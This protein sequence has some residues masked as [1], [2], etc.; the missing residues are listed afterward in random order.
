[1]SAVS[2]TEAKAHLNIAANL[3]DEELQSFLDRAEAAIGQRVGPVGS[4]SIEDERVRGYCAVLRLAKAPIISLTSVVPVGSGG[5][6]DV[7][8]LTPLSGGRVVFLQ[9]G[10]FTARF[11]DVTYTAGRAVVPDDLKLAVL[12]LV[13]HL[14]DT[15]RS[16]GAA[17]I[18][19]AANET[20]ANTIPGAAYMFPFRVEQLLAPYVPVLGA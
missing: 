10:I 12:E 1:M 17:R 13:R 15:Q 9:G 2:L 6:V 19:S 8:Q 16:G 18:G 11:Y 3:Q 7:T 5:A 14:F 4:V 20:V